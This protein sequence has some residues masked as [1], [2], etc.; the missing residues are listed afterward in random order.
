MCDHPILKSGYN[1]EQ[2]LK[3]RAYIERTMNRSLEENI[4]EN[5]LM[6]QVIEIEKKLE[7][8]DTYKK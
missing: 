8:Y 2:E 5:N 3:R 7:K 1:Y 4:E 6:K